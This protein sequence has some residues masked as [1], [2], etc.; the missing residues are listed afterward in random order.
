MSKLYERGVVQYKNAEF[1]WKSRSTNDIYVD[2]ACFNLHQ[3]IEFLLKYLIEMT[4]N[5]YPETHD[6]SVLIENL[7]NYNSSSKTFEY[8][9]KKANVYNTW[10]T[11]ALRVDS[12]IASV[13]DIEDAFKICKGLFELINEIRTSVGIPAEAINWCRNNAP[14]ALKGASDSE[15]WKYMENIYYKYSGG[16]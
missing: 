5:I 4:G 13:Y 9:E 12:F 6:L 2:T 1:N 8:I 7:K 10:Y 16:E 14:E 11:D 15:L 3:A